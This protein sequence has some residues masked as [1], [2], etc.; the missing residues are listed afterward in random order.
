MKEYGGYFSL[1]LYENEEYYIYD[2]NSVRRCNSARSAIVDAVRDGKYR[3]IWAPIYTC[4]SIKKTLQMSDIEYVEYNINEQFLPVDVSVASGEI[5][6]WTNY[7]GVFQE[8]WI[9]D[10]VVRRYKNVIIDNT[11][12]F[13]TVPQMDVYNVYSCKKFFGVADGAYLIHEGLAE[14]PFKEYFSMPSAEFLLSSLENGTNGAYQEFLCHEKRLETEIGGRMSELTRRIMAS[15][16]YHEVMEKRGRNY[17][18]I[19]NRL[20]E[21]NELHFTI[22]DQIPMVYP[23]LVKNETLRNYLVANKV[24]IS[25]WWKWI[26]EYSGSN[27]FERYLSKYLIPLPIDQRYG[28]ED[29]EEIVRIVKEGL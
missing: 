1:E 19:Q 29:M 2:S 20:D 22:T 8:K 12:S 24:Y 7:F 5:I 3:R 21:Y 4:D 9:Q 28:V 16:R 27:E 26:I 11:Q 17:R 15:I 6:L 18:Y 10:N 14:Q 23:L 13:F 25:Q